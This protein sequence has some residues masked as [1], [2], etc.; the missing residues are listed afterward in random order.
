MK[1]ASRKL[2]KRKVLTHFWS[3]FTKNKKARKS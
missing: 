2:L 3:K 1:S